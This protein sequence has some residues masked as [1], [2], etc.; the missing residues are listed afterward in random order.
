MHALA[1]RIRTLVAETPFPTSIG[2]ITITVS[3]GAVASDGLAQSADPLVDTADAALLDA[4]R[5]GKNR[6][7]IARRP[8]TARAAA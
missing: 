3:V 6:I 7:V 8:P 5:S 1:E 2:Q 4:K